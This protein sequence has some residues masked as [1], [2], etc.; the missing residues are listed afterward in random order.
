MGNN[1]ISDTE[2]FTYN[3]LRKLPENFLCNQE[4]INGLDLYARKSVSKFVFLHADNYHLIC[5]ED[6]GYWEDGIWFSNSGYKY[7]AIYSVY[8]SDYDWT[9]R[10][11]NDYIPTTYRKCK[12]CGVYD[13]LSKMS[14][15]TKNDWLCNKCNYMR[16]D[17]GDVLYDERFSNEQ[18]GLEYDGKFIQRLVKCKLCGQLENTNECIILDNGAAYCADCWHDVVSC[19]PI[20]CPVCTNTVTLKYDE[21]CPMCN[22]QLELKDYADQF[23]HLELS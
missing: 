12:L 6:L 14:W 4:I 17:E 5:N 19:F 2:E 20:M 1:I 21:T 18:L 11:N 9:G 15:T 7:G 16:P 3:V 10:M 23:E 8:A 22:I 13:S